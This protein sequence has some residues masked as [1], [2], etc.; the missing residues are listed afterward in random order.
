MPRPRYEDI[1]PSGTGLDIRSL[2][3][4]Q[5]GYVSGMS[6]P[7][8]P[9]F[10]PALAELLRTGAP[11]DTR[12]AE[13]AASSASMRAFR[14][15]SRQINEAMLAGGKGGSSAQTA[16][17]AEAGS[18]ISSRLGERIAEL[19][20]GAG[21]AAAGRRLGALNPALGQG[22]LGLQARSAQ[23]G[24]G[25]DLLNLLKTL[26][27]MGTGGGEL[28]GSRSSRQLGQGSNRAPVSGAGT[29]DV[30]G[31]LQKR[32]LETKLAAARGL[33]SGP[34][35]LTPSDYTPSG[36]IR[37]DVNQR[38]MQ[39]LAEWRNRMAGYAGVLGQPDPTA[40]G[41]QA[42]AAKFASV[43]QPAAG[44]A[45]SGP[46]YQQAQQQDF[47]RKLI[48]EYGPYFAGLAQGG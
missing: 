28:A 1:F 22:Q 21:E 11:V 45:V 8:S 6:A 17:L 29:T 38:Y 7:L 10:D 36:G 15:I 19:K 13:S 32:L 42:E 12:G 48:E 14:D 41:Q 47:I 27:P 33:M 20:Y 30:L 31:N 5:A 34:P 26:M 35:Q 4:N 3:G 23:A 37:S 18:D 24:A 16:R 39:Q 2:L 9:E 25:M 46:L 44:A 43:N 40:A